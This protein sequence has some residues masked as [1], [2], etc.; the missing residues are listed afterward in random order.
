MYVVLLSFVV[1][2]GN[3]TRDINT[4]YSFN[5][6]N[7]FILQYAVLRKKNTKITLALILSFKIVR[8]DLKRLMFYV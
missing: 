3:E 2:F 4:G 8:T 5:I 1:L 7:G 6:C